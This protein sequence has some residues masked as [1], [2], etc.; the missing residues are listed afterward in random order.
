MKVV[1]LLLATNNAK[2]VEEIRKLLPTGFKLL[3]LNDIGF[4]DE[5]PETT[6]TIEG[7]SRQ[8]AW[9]VFSRTGMNCLSDDSGLEINALDNRP[10]VDS[11]HYAGLPPN[12]FENIDLIFREMDGEQDRSARFVTVMTLVIEGNEYQF[13]GEISG[14]ITT[15]PLGVNGFGYDPIFIPQGYE[16][17]FAQMEA[18]DKNQ[19]SHRAKALEKLKEFFSGKIE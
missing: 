6:N 5:I 3:K 14:A 15:T 1:K 12:N 18:F 17:T 16:S 13:H 11:A 19:I 2:K 9:Y 10:G 8:K 4:F 7:N